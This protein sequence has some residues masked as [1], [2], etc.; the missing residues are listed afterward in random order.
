MKARWS[1]GTTVSKVPAKS[2]PQNGIEL[3]ETVNVLQQSL[4][5]ISCNFK[6]ENANIIFDK[7]KQHKTVRETHGKCYR[8]LIT[9]LNEAFIIPKTFRKK[10]SA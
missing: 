3:F 10:S 4:N 8:G 1:D 9:G 6:T 5:E 7:L 2:L